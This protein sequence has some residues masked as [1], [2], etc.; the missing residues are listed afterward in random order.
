MIQVIVLQPF[1]PFLNSS[2]FFSQVYQAFWNNT[3]YGDPIY[4][5][6]DTSK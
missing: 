3:S 5:K 6:F 1:T 2:H 4:L